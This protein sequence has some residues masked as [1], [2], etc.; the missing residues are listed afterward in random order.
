MQATRDGNANG[1]GPASSPLSPMSTSGAGDGA[2]AAELRREL[3]DTKS[4]LQRTR[5]ERDSLSHQLQD[6]AG[7]P[8]TFSMLQGQ[9][10]T[11]RST[12]Q[13]RVRDLESALEE[14][15][16]ERGGL[17]AQIEAMTEEVEQA[18]QERVLMNDEIRRL[19]DA[20]VNQASERTGSRSERSA[21]FGRSE[22]FGSAEHDLRLELDRVVREHSTHVTTLQNEIANLRSEAQAARRDRGM[23]EGHTQQLEQLRRNNEQLRREISKLQQQMASSS[24]REGGGEGSLALESKVRGLEGTITQLNEELGT[25]DRRIA[26]VER[27]HQDEKK[28]IVTSFDA[29]R[30]QYQLER[31]ECDALVLKMTSELEFLV[32]ENASLR[33]GNTSLGSGGG[34]HTPTPS[35]G[36][37]RR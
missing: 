23:E 14:G 24:R 19:R 25:V 20:H 7:S 27:Q 28:K 31:E 18:K 13:Q 26:D 16:S 6:N 2:V 12:L 35:R 3:E 5:E 15:R 34:A 21:G 37:D 36:Y 29:E 11:E 1:N 9:W 30:R 32:R 17:G 4:I 8:A 33:N 22:T 10:H